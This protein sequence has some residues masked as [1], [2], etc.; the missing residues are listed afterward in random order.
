MNVSAKTQKVVVWVVFSNRFLSLFALSQRNSCF[1][2][3]KFL[4]IIRMKVVV[5]IVQSIDIF[6]YK[7]KKSVVSVVTAPSPDFPIL[8][9]VLKTVGEIEWIEYG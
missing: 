4:A 9:H 6:S 2:C 8:K 5:S 7:V 1:R 3:M